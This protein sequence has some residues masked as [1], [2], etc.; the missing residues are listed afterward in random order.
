MAFA[1]I[2]KPIPSPLQL[3]HEIQDPINSFGYERRMVVDMRTEL[4]AGIPV[5][6]ITFFASLETES[7]PI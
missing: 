1:P 4:A 2:P 7:L 5:L 6:K 3:S